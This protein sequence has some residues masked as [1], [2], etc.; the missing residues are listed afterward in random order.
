MYRNQYNRT[1][2]FANG[3]RQNPPANGHA[4]A[5]DAQGI[6]RPVSAPPSNYR[7]RQDDEKQAYVRRYL[8]EMARTA[9]SSRPASVSLI[10][11]L[12]PSTMVFTLRAKLNVIAV[13][14]FT[15][16]VTWLDRL[17]EVYGPQVVTAEQRVGTPTGTASSS[18]Q[19]TRGATRAEIS[20]LNEPKAELERNKHNVE[21]HNIQE[22]MRTEFTKILE[23]ELDFE[24]FI[25][26]DG[27]IVIPQSDRETVIPFTIR[28]KR[29]PV[30]SPPD[31]TYSWTMTRGPYFLV[32][33][34]SLAISI[35]K[36]GTQVD[37]SGPIKCEEGSALFFWLKITPKYHG[38]IKDTLV[39]DFGEFVICRYLSLRVEDISIL[40]TVKTA[41]PVASYV[42]TRRP[43]KVASLAPVEVL[44]GVPP[45]KPDFRRLLPTPMGQYPVPSEVREF[46]EDEDRKRFESEDP[47]PMSPETYSKTF[48]ELMW[49]E[50]LQMERDIRKYDMNG[51]DLIHNP[52]SPRFI[53]KVAGLA[54]GR[55]SVLYGDRV[56]ARRS[57]LAS[58][59]EWEGFVHEVNKEELWL[60]FNPRFLAEVYM[61]KMKFNVRFAYTRIPLRSCHQAIGLLAR[62]PDNVKFP[63]LTADIGQTNA[64]P[65][66]PLDLQSRGMFELNE[67]Q[68]IAVTNI[69]YRKH[70]SAPY[71][72]YGPPGTGKTKTLCEAICQVYKSFGRSLSTR[73]L[74]LAPSNTAADQLCERLSGV[75]SPSEMFRLNSYRRP[76]DGIPAKIEPH[77]L[78]DTKSSP[79]LFRMPTSAD[80]MRYKI[81]VA[82]CISAGFLYNMGLPRGH[83]SSFFVDEAGQA[84]E[85]EFWI[86]IAGLIDYPRSQIVLAGDPQQLGP[87]LRSTDAKKFGLEKS[88][89][90]RLLE[91]PLYTPKKSGNT[92]RIVEALPTSLPGQFSENPN[93]IT[94]LLRNYRS[95]PAILNISSSLFYN[96]ELIASAEKTSRDSLTDVD[97]LP[98]KGFPIIFCGV[99]G[100]DM[101]EGDS[102]SWF[103]PD[104]VGWVKKWVDTIG[105][106]RSKGV[107]FDQIG[108]IAP[109]RRQVQRI[110]QLLKLYGNGVKCGTVEEF[111]GQERRII[112][113]STV[114]SSAS[115]VSSDVF[116]SL[117]FLKNAKRFNVAVSRAKQLL[118][119]IGN[120]MVLNQDRHWAAFLKYCRDHGAVVGY[121]PQG[122]GAGNPSNINTLI[123]SLQRLRMTEEKSAEEERLQA[124]EAENQGKG[125]SVTTAQEDPSWRRE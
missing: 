50:E 49:V 24:R 26:P 29:R 45:P 18:S 104:E 39:F 14:R 28:I 51:V 93:V 94:K 7:Q 22:S 105:R 89:L 16:L 44:P 74:V 5:Q 119:V 103:N 116:H 121:D 19:Q 21:V 6:R 95:H 98:A 36:R 61:A 54:E 57:D 125:I 90:E 32:G 85:P 73:F 31:G 118:V 52:N 23:D 8:S 92:G 72:I 106:A 111:Q 97:F 91:L 78:I 40:E 107:S 71:V 82:T 88:F 69:V 81:V 38:V 79:Q 33:D 59:I 30:G 4:N 42:G 87:I 9:R 123:N 100:R 84:T 113:I 77:C 96:K 110:Q 66:K 58:G 122:S 112:I 80:V 108:I 70:G 48:S 101:Q 65:D 53:L 83:F 86:G 17:I 117:G 55:P 37:L 10:T 15:K 62:L 64:T 109:Y 41:E 68:R 43:P 13:D 25:D 99:N 75:F 34:P 120:P 11:R 60:Q 63:T 76:V 35:P 20:L 46:V 102:P 12:S 2:P 124:I 56:F 1:P 115:Q 67:E 114:R 27:T 47:F 3:G